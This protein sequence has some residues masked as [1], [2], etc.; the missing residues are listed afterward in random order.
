MSV[1]GSPKAG[2]EEPLS[3]LN[4][5][6]HTAAAVVDTEQ[7]HSHLSL[8]AEAENRATTEAAPPQQD[9]HTHDDD[10]APHT[11]ML[12]GPF[13]GWA[14]TEELAQAIVSLGDIRRGIGATSTDVIARRIIEALDVEFRV[15]RRC[16]ADQIGDKQGLAHMPSADRDRALGRLTWILAAVD[17]PGG[18]PS[19]SLARV[20]R[21][22]DPPAALV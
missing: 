13:D 17:D 7:A 12:R 10:G 14:R 6:D 5:A 2:A 1:W 3:R 15:I 20:I 9:R 4:R 11:A 18:P 21:T 8:P 22:L 19:P 16:L